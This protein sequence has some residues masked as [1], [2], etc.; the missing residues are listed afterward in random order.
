MASI[1]YIIVFVL[2]ALSGC[3]AASVARSVDVSDPDVFRSR[4]DVGPS[5]EDL[6]PIGV[7]SPEPRS[8][9]DSAPIQPVSAES[10]TSSTAVANYSGEIQTGERLQLLETVSLALAQ[11]PDLVA[12]RQ[13]D[14]QS[15][16][17]RVALIGDSFTFG[18]EVAYEETWAHRVS[19]LLGPR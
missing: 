15:D 16:P 9:A 6:N 11:N 19:L 1:R 4:S 17:V 5:S 10:T 12:L 7:R 3:R 8:E 13:T 2:L 18:A 14:I